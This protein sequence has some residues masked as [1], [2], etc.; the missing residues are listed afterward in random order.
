MN[1]NSVPKFFPTL[2]LNT[3]LFEN[4]TPFTKLVQR[5][6]LQTIICL[7]VRNC[8]C[9]SH[10]ERP[11][12]CTH[13]LTSAMVCYSGVVQTVVM[14]YSLC[15]VRR[16]HIMCTCAH[17]MFVELLRWRCCP[18]AACCVLQVYT[19]SLM[20]SSN[21]LRVDCV[22]KNSVNL[23]KILSREFLKIAKGQNSARSCTI[24]FGRPL[25]LRLEKS[26]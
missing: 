22:Q 11:N 12:S 9:S 13:H 4:L 6:N 16:V 5:Q 24:S 19:T 14:K 7:L 23:I 25:T 3:N 20:R 18:P 8:R 15:L 2:I 21:V 17:M 10:I 1:A 26:K